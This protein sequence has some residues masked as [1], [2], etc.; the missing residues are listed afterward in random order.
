MNNHQLVALNKSNS[1]TIQALYSELV[2]FYGMEGAVEVLKSSP[3]WDI[4]VHPSGKMSIDTKGN[5]LNFPDWVINAMYPVSKPFKW[6][7][8]GYYPEQEKKI[9]MGNSPY[10]GDFKG[11]LDAVNYLNSQ[12]WEWDSE[13]L[14]QHGVPAE[15]LKS[16]GDSGYFLWR[17]DARGRVYSDSFYINPQGEEYQKASINLSKGEPLTDEGY[18]WVLI[19]LANAYGHDKLSWT[20]RMIWAEMVING[21]VDTSNPEEPILFNKL[22]KSIREYDGGEWNVPVALDATASGIQIMGALSGDKATCKAG[23]LIGNERADIYSEIAKAMTE[24]LGYEI[25]RSK[26]KKPIMT[27]YYNSE[28]NPKEAFNEKELEVFYAVLNSA[29]GGAEKVMESINS[30]WEDKSKF[31]WTLP[32]GFQTQ[33]TTTQVVGYEIELEDGLQFYWERREESPSGD[34]RHLVPNV[35]HSL[36]GWVCREVVRHMARNNLPIFTIHD[37]FWSHPNYMGE[38]R[39][40]YTKS[41]SYINSENLL[42]GIIKELGGEGY[43]NTNLHLDG[44]YYLS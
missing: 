10:Y 7:S 4:I 44:E 6:D 8:K 14:M 40:A 41:M 5:K 21:L 28:S 38:V 24:T 15:F 12:K 29:L 27:H 33:I 37:S 22:L 43:E 31:R 42:D 35:I 3:Y 30:V 1:N 34:Y 36:D 19:A 18:K 17:M 23:N 20:D 32:D 39:K 16:V 2:P 11:A 26:V 13:L 9:I 25:S